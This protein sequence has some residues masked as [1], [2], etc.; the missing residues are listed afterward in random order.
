MEVS[1]QLHAPADVL[2]GRQP[3]VPIVEEAE[4]APK[5]RSGR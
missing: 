1:G 2:P 4:W 5:S 3:T